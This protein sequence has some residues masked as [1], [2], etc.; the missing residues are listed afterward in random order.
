MKKTFMVFLLASLFVISIE[1]RVFAQMTGQVEKTGRDLEKEKTLREKIEKKIEPPK[2]EQPPVQETVPSTSQE[3]TLVKQ[4]TVTGVTLVKQKDIDAII[5]AY[6]NKELYMRDMQKIA[7]LI[8]DLYR[9]KGYITSR[10]YLPP[11]KIESGVLE[12]RVIEGITGDINIKGN[13]YFKTALLRDKIALK[14]GQ[15]FDYEVLKKGMSRINEQPDL[16]AKAVLAPGKDPGTTDVVLEVKDKLPIHA[17]LTY[18]NYASRFLDKDRIKTTVSHNNLLG[19]EDIFTIQYQLTEGENYTLVSANYLLPVTESL[20]LG[21]FA[22]N[23]K[24]SLRRDYE[25]LNARGKSKYCS[26]FAV[27]S[28]FTRD[29][30]SLKLNLGFDYKDIYNFQL[31]QET[32]RDRMR[33]AKAGLEFDMSD[34]FGRTLLTNE[35]DFGIPDIIGGLKARDSFA[36]QG[37]DA[38]KGT[39]GSR[40][41]SGGEFI[42]H[43]LNFVRLQRLP[44]DNIFYWKSQAQITSNILTAAE[45]FQIGGIANVRGYPAAEVVGDRGFSSTMAWSIPFYFIPKSFIVPFSKARLYDSIRLVTFYDWANARLRKPAAGE[46]KD[47]TLRSIGYGIRIIMPDG[48]SARIEFAWP[49]DNMP[50]DGHHMHSWT[51]ISKSF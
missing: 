45:Q 14:K 50:S 41:G 40:D 33:V 44:F 7:D 19:F 43:A 51:E 31:G 25:D 2:I 29:N 23:T 21:L 26:L 22:A 17:G 32:S 1:S 15:A 13:R 28:L 46:Q 39:G 48:F 42:K 6:S 38:S 4:I 18:D 11:Q 27:Q 3:K 49:L 35:V 37:T 9:K 20:K 16:N 12:V 34:R 24:L 36:S 5:S 47:R 10:A 30:A 8:T